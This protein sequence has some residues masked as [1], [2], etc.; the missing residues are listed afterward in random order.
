MLNVD[1]LNL[2]IETAKCSDTDD[3]DYTFLLNT[4]KL[5]FSSPE[6][7]GQSFMDVHGEFDT[8]S[9]L[10]CYNILVEL[11]SKVDIMT[12]LVHSISSAI[13]ALNLILKN[14]SWS[15]EAMM[16]VFYICLLVAIS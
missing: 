12:P 4:I 7:L 16:R 14:Q 15:E 10:H 6:A 3:V 9:V 2:S 13:V 1:L 11:D 8:H 5:V